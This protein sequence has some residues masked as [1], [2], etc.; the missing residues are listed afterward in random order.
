MLA[1]LYVDTGEQS[2]SAY[3]KSAAYA[4]LKN[5]RAAMNLAHEVLPNSE[6]EIK[7]A[8]EIRAGL[9]I[10]AGKA[11][12][13]L[14]AY[15]AALKSG[16]PG[17]VHLENA[18]GL[19]DGIDQVD[20]GFAPA[21]RCRPTWRK[22]NDA[23]EAALRS[24]ETAAEGKQWDEA[25]K[26]IQPYRQF[27]GEQPR[28]AHVLDSAYAAYLLQ[29]Q[30]L[31]DSKDWQNAIVSFQNALKVKDTAEAH[32][33]LKTAQKELAAMQDQAGG[34]CCP[35]KEQGIRAAARHDPGVRGADQP[36]R[37]A[38]PDRE[39]RDYAAGSRLHYR[40]FAARQRHRGRLSDHPGHRG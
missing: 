22:A 20:P 6:G 19:V 36:S 1:G 21:K 35:G 29:G 13:E 33:D 8:G 37:R 30:Q 12:S 24:A 17:F 10:L 38:A 40:R 7:L 32:E 39:G 18:K 11:F 16:T 26:Q 31:E 27:A 14:E 34:E 23:F 15:N 9:D 25:L 2:L 5:A 28:V 4:D 3:Q